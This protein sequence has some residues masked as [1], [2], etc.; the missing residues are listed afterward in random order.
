MIYQVFLIRSCCLEI[1][2]KKQLV[3]SDNA[4]EIGLTQWKQILVFPLIR[5]EVLNIKHKREKLK[6][7]SG[8]SFT[9]LRFLTS[10][11]KQKFQ[12]KIKQFVHYDKLLH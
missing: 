7:V 3:D 11:S 8:I 4:S 5:I 1:Y 10:D 2:L 9:L 12:C 6:G